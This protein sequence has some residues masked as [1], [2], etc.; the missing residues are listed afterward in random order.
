MAKE[1]KFITCDGNEAAVILIFNKTIKSFY[2]AAECGAS[3]KAAENVVQ[4][5]LHRR[6][7]HG[8]KRHDKNIFICFY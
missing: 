8:V 2:C 5:D 6:R 4:Y 7:R 3:G 1:K